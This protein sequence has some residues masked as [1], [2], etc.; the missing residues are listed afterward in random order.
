MRGDAHNFEFGSNTERI[1]QRKDE[2]PF[3]EPQIKKES[4]KK[5]KLRNVIK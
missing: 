5:K 2:V 4:I 3:E 1:Q